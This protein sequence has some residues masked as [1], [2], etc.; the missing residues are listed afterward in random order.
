[1]QE[2]VNGRARFPFYKFRTMRVDADDAAHR[3]YQR[4]FIAGAPDA[5][6]GDDARPAYKLRGDN[7]VTRIGTV[8]RRLSLDNCRNC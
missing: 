1:L 3:E 2:R 6:L 5:N 4:R 8:L 7:R